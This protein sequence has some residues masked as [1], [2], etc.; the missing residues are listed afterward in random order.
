MV[1][2]VTKDEQ[3]VKNGGVSTREVQFA[4]AT[5]GAILYNTKVRCFAAPNEREE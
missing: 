3:N 4:L 2:F 5:D 1:C